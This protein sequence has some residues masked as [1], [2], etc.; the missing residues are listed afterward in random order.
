MLQRNARIAEL[1][2]QALGGIPGV[3]FAPPMPANCEPVVWLACV[4][5]PPD[6]RDALLVE[7]QRAGLEMRPFFH[8]LSS[9]PPYQTHAR[10]CSNSR[11]LS[12]TGINLPTSRMV[13]ETVVERVARV[14]KH[15][16]A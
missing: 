1:Y 14:F 13:D 9:L 5:V 2:A 16:L 6:K 3:S 10:T 15:V 12:A 8:P 7:S 4:L 11:A